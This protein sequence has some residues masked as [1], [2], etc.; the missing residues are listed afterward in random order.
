[1]SSSMSSSSN[2]FWNSRGKM[3]VCKTRW[4]LSMAWMNAMGILCRAWSW[5]LWPSQWLSMVIRFLSSGQFSVVLNP[6][7]IMN[8]HH[9]LAPIFCPRSS[10]LC[11]RAMMAISS[12]TFVTSSVFVLLLT[13]FLEYTLDI[14]VSIAVGLWIYAAT[15][16][17]FM[18]DQH[19]VSPQQ[20]LEDILAFHAWWIQLNAKSNA[21]AKLDAFYKM[22]M[23]CISPE[24]H[25]PIVQQ[26]LLVCHTVSVAALH[27]TSNIF[28]LTLDEL[29]HALSKL[30]SVLTFIPEEKRGWGELFPGSVHIS[31]YHAFFMEFLLDKTWSGEYWL[32]D[33]CH[34]TALVSKVLCLFKA[35]YVMNGISCGVSFFPSDISCSK[36]N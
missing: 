30:Y 5:S 16:V 23:D 35:L 8:S 36:W 27:T 10:C 25:L 9:T 3:W 15:L 6:I 32:E 13:L 14:L 20:Q 22:I 24:H 12:A 19:A 4:W 1:M 7:S 18:M 26:L 17:R 34:Y 21:T 11:Q 2:H 31:F 28:G 33:Q 29:K